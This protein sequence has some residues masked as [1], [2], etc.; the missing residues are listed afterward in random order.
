VARGEIEATAARE[1]LNR[2]MG[3]Q[4]DALDWKLGPHL[5]P[6]PAPP[7]SAVPLAGLEDTAMASRQDLAALREDAEAAAR[8]LPAARAAALGAEAEAGAHHERDADGA[9]TTGPAV[10][11]PVPIFNWGQAARA[12]AEARYRQAE[13]RRRARLAEVRSE[14]RDAWGRLAVARR[15]AELYRD[16]LVPLSRSVVE[17]TQTQYNAMLAGVFQLLEARKDQARAERGAIEALRDYWLARTELERAV[18]AR[19]PAATN[20]ASAAAAPTAAAPAVAAPA[21][22]A[23]SL[24]LVPSPA[25]GSLRGEP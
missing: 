14:V 24:P 19:L 9:A 17:L 25:P 22:A 13:L 16:T 21:A 23:P 4:D 3:L 2:D 6:L 15:E 7:D 1:R 20:A 11:A 5:P 8:A 18:A 10:T 12:R